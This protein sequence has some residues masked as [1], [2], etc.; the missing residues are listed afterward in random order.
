[1]DVITTIIQNS[2]LNGMPKWYQ[3]ISILLFAIIASIILTMYAL[4]FVNGSD[5]IIRFGY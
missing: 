2:A 4:L 5:M 1:M 3:A